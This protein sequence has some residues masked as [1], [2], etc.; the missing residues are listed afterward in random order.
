M[1]PS[2]II[3]GAERAPG[4]I[5]NHNRHTAIKFPFESAAIWGLSAGMSLVSEKTCM[6]I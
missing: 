5:L 4:A 6:F 3:K 1:N 2:A